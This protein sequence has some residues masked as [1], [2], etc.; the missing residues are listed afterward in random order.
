MAVV[1]LKG[2][3]LTARLSS[4]G[5]GVLGLW[6]ERGDLRLPLLREAPSDDADASTSGCFPLVPFGNRVRDNRF[7][8]RGRS[9]ALEANT[10]RDPHYLHGDGWRSE[11]FVLKE[12]RSEVE[13]GFSNEGASTPYRYEARQ[14]FAIED[15]S[16]Q[17]DLRVKNVGAEALPFGLGWHPYFP[18]TPAATLKAPARRFW[19]EVEGWLPG[20]VTEIPGDLDFSL[21]R[22]LPQRWVNNGFEGW[23]GTAE[24]TWPE[25]NSRL[26]LTAGEGMKHY[27]IFVSDATFDPNFRNDYFCF[28]PMSHMADGHNLPDLGGLVVLEPGEAMSVSLRMRPE[29]IA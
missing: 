4:R 22:G 18:M 10:A 17:V 9:Y 23:D 8:F 19:T 26:V 16:F 28:E 6:W 24:I 21:P 13:F 15:D 25:R 1:E 2:R 11:W 12:S 3:D 20:E 5:G 29:S 14:R 7:M 27:F